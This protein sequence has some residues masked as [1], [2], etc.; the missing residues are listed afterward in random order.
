MVV[1]DEFFARQLNSEDLKTYIVAK[2]KEVFAGATQAA[3][4]W[5]DGDLDPQQRQDLWDFFKFRIT[6]TDK[7][8]KMA[9][10][11]SCNAAI[12]AGRIWVHE[13]C[14]ELLYQLRNAAF[15]KESQHFIRTERMGHC[16]MISALVTAHRSFNRMSRWDP[17]PT[18]GTW[19]GEQ[20]I[21]A[22][23]E[24]VSDLA[25]VNERTYYL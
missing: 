14:T 13:R 5:R 9:A 16:D 11:D 23:E 2:E 12:S 7:H 1:L 25:L 19:V 10:I 8:D 3:E 18:V 4:M 21:P 15:R 22:D 17:Y 6:I 20:F 24:A